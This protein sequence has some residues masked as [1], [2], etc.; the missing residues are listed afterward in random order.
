[1]QSYPEYLTEKKT[2]HSNNYKYYEYYR[3]YYWL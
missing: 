3:R 2:I 1:M